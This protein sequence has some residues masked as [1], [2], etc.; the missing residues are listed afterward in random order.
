M[1][2]CYLILDRFVC[3]KTDVSHLKNIYYFN[4]VNSDMELLNVFP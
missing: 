1:I 2:I 4:Q 3:L